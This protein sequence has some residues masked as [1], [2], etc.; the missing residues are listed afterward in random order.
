MNVYTD[1]II[2]TIVDASCT[3]LSYTVY[4]DLIISTIVDALP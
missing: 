1:L 4:T 2:S 3:H